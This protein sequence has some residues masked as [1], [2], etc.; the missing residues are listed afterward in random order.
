MSRMRRYRTLPLLALRRMAGNWKLLM[1]VAVGSV[2][3]AAILSATAI[4]SD[5][6]RDLGLDHAIGQKDIRELDLVV[7]QSNI[8]VEAER[9]ERSQARQSSEVVWA[10]QNSF[11]EVN[12]LARSATYFLS[13]TDGL[14]GE[15]D[16]VRPR[17]NFM[18]RSGVLDQIQITEG[19]WPEPQ[20]TFTGGPIQVAV[21]ER[22]AIENDLS[23]GQSLII[24]PFWEQDA[25][26]VEVSIVGLIRAIDEEHRYWGESNY[27]RIDGKDRSWATYLLWIPE[28]SA[29]GILR[30]ASKTVTA[31]YRNTYPLQSEMLNSRNSGAIA[32]GLTN[33]Y[34]N[35]GTTEIRVTTQT[36]LPELLRT[37]DQKLFFTRI[38]L[39]VLLLQGGGIVAYYLVT[40]STMLVDRQSAE[41]ATLRSRGATTNQLLTQYGIEGVIL[42]ALAIGLGPFVAASVISALGPTPAFSGLS[43]GTALTVHIGGLAY[44]LAGIG[45]L[46]AFISL[47]FPAWRATRNTVVEY[48]K[49]QARP[50]RP[51]LFLR[52]YLDVVFVIVLAFGYWRIS[53]EDSLVTQQFFETNDAV[54]PFLL[55][56][57]AV[58]MVT[59]GVV[60]LRLFP[61]TLRVISW[62]LGLTRSVALLVGMRSLVRN[63]GNY[64]R[65]VL[66]LMFATGVGMFGA[67]FSATLDRSYSDRAAYTVGADVRAVIGLSNESLGKEGISR[68]LNLPQDIGSSFVLRSRGTLWVDESNPREIELIGIEPDSFAETAFLRTDFSE[69]SLPDLITN[70]GS[71]DLYLDG[72]AIPASA[73]QIGL[74]LKFTDLAGRINVNTVLADAN[75]RLSHFSM[76][77]VR[78]GDPSTS[79]WV[80]FTADVTEPAD[81]FGKTKA[82]ELPFELRGVSFTA[83]SRLTAQ[84]ASIKIGALVYT[85]LDVP[86]PAPEG[87][88]PDQPSN[89][90]FSWYFGLDGGPRGNKEWSDS[91]L[92][93]DFTAGGFRPL[94]GA[95]STSGSDSLLLKVDAPEGY[96][97][98]TELRWISG[99]GYR[100]LHGLMLDVDTGDL[101][102]YLDR[103]TAETFD[104]AVGQRLAL[105]TSSRWT[106]VRY[107][108][109]FDY[110]PSYDNNSTSGFALVNGKRLESAVNIALP[111]N[112]ISYNELWL[113]FPDES[114]DISWLNESVLRQLLVAS[115]IRDEQQDDPLIAAG[116]SGILAIS[117]GSVLLLSA[118]GFMVYSYLNAQQRSLEFAIMRT[119]GFSKTQVFSLVLFEHLFVVLAGLGLGTGVGLFIG[120]FMMT[121]LS[122]DEFGNPVSPNFILEVSWSEVAVVWG[123]LSLVFVAT[124]TAVVALYFRLAIHKALRIGDA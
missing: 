122:N 117:F 12:R 39:L 32:L 51:P 25:Q 27:V 59:V 49:G 114:S 80:L 101:T 106:T 69:N 64:S 50:D 90:N 46:I 92:I 30:A 76:G 98:S 16:S 41:I 5:A 43:G 57:P 94:S 23:V 29:H 17:A 26:P 3:A 35:L 74:W 116:W 124:V 93:H 4:Y 18:W 31:D 62:L 58:F 9:Y 6:I 97:K 65:L 110:L 91:E 63:P 48:K 86:P 102:I 13:D 53:R 123:I 108:G 111:D 118:I 44:F 2:C 89:N 95:R 22:T 99:G 107:G 84:Q 8:P 71:E 75:G 47:M 1:S 79:E 33:L 45:A 73:R 120:R 19:R 112:S 37:Y 20:T 21:G 36:D 7:L 78:P 109:N 105:A 83:S 77:A 42:A 52:L 10:S 11:T 119:L 100:R 14:L 88:N 56:T 85:T 70:L 40:V 15:P 96:Q 72:P 82:A 87:L 61:P 55:A 68:D 67:T 38:P 66:L 60:F 54:D 113:D 24:Y 103:T 34:A 28:T 115:V 121:F 104:L 81:K